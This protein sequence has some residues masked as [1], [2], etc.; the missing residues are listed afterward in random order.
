MGDY[1]DISK[2]FKT[3][4]NQG[5]KIKEVEKIMDMDFS[6][7]IRFIIDVGYAGITAV[8]SPGV[9][10][11]KDDGGLWNIRLLEELSPEAREAT[12]EIW[13]KELGTKVDW[14]RRSTEKFI[15]RSERE[16]QTILRTT[17][18]HTFLLGTGSVTGIPFKEAEKMVKTIEPNLELLKTYVGMKKEYELRHGKP[19]PLYGSSELSKMAKFKLMDECR[20]FPG[21]ELVVSSIIG[22]AKRNA[23]KPAVIGATA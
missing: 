18:I 4:Q 23:A 2:T 15:K 16:Y 14:I 3:T 12:F 6:H 5:N 21:H 19:L 17:P 9:V 8:R 22:I 20:R 11:M 7:A 13:Q 1:Y 10:S